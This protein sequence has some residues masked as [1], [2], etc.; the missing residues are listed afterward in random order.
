MEVIGQLRDIVS[1]WKNLLRRKKTAPTA[2]PAAPAIRRQAPADAALTVHTRAPAALGVR[3]P[4]LLGI[5]GL[6]I[7]AFVGSFLSAME[8]PAKK[9]S[10]QA[11]GALPVAPAAVSAGKG[12]GEN[13]SKGL[14][15]NYQDLARY[16]AVN[17]PGAG[18][19]SSG[20]ARQSSY[21]SRLP[22][23][24]APSYAAERYSEP[25]YPEPVR[26]SYAV[27]RYSQPPVPAPP[28]TLPGTAPAV[29][30]TADES[31]LSSPVRFNLPQAKPETPAAAPPAADATAK[32]EYVHVMRVRE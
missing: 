3:K 2:Q 25:D 7:A 12:F 5:A 32:P 22:A 18:Q 30:A 19:G 21:G 1:E 27:R 13:S 24:S 28:G 23:A 16:N 4:L 8:E 10:G 11:A 15:A 26:D 17:N 9:P 20:I 14:P 6:F 31:F 29:P